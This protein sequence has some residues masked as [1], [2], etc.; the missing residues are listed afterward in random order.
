MGSGQGCIRQ[1]RSAGQHDGGARSVSKLLTDRQ[2]QC[3]AGSHR[4]L[5]VQAWDWGREMKPSSSFVFVWRNLLKILAPPAYALRLLSKSACIPQVL[6][7]LL[8]L[9]YI[10]PGLVVLLSLKGQELSFQLPSGS[11]G[12]KLSDF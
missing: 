2:L 1:G 12:A 11:R 4:C 10:L 9:C 6:F 3:S 5:Y 7:K 8:L